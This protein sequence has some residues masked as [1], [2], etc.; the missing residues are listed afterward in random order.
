MSNTAVATSSLRLSS[1]ISLAV[2]LA[3]VMSAT[4]SRPA[5]ADWLQTYVATRCAAA[6]GTGIV[7]FGYADAVDPAKFAALDPSTMGPI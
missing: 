2:V 7:Q 6:S 1:S 5:R 4:V 3:A